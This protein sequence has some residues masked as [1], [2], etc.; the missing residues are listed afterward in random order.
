MRES[1]RRLAT[2]LAAL[3][4]VGIAIAG[5]GESRPAFSAQELV[6]QA[7]A[8]GAGLVLGEPLD[9][10]REGAEAHEV[11]F[12]EVG[13]AHA[14]EA[15]EHGHGGGTLTIT[16]DADAGLAEYERCESAATLLCFR[17]A[18]AVLFFE[19]SLDPGDR[20]RL[21]QALMRMASEE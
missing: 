12:E 16:A 19:S 9:I 5:C 1:R 6:D 7:N 8:N 14:D 20:G 17:A 18:N 10:E 13:A 4:A 2:P 3:I 11:T 15:S 21:E